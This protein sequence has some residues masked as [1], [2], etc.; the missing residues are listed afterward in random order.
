MN[1]DPE[2]PSPSS[3]RRGLSDGKYPGN[4]PEIAHVAK[5][6]D[7]AEGFTGTPNL[8]T[9]PPSLPLPS[10]PPVSTRLRRRR[11]R[12]LPCEAEPRETKLCF[13][14][15]ADDKER[16]RHYWVSHKEYAKEQGI[17]DTK[18]ECKFCGMKFLRRDN[19]KK[20]IKNHSILERDAADQDT[21][22]ASSEELTDLE[23]EDFTD[24]GINSD[25]A[26]A[27]PAMDTAEPRD[28]LDISSSIRSS[29][30][31]WAQEVFDA[32]P[33]VDDM[34]LFAAEKRARDA[35]AAFNAQFS[36]IRAKTLEDKND[37][38]DGNKE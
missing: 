35:L 2:L 20:H 18:S 7:W 5:T 31:D 19:L 34:R 1:I 26:V 10:I 17:E 14:L 27:T 12:D 33:R 9:S 28:A 13:K 6:L 38:Q 16:R 23:D 4:E 8:L 3:D 22:R 37:R 15:F 24:L 25:N 36:S 30:D 21:M 11:N 32:A 29:I